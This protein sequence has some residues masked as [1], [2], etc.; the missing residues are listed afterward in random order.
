MD[1][2]V[3]TSYYISIWLTPL[4][5]SLPPSLFI[6]YARFAYYEYIKLASEEEPAEEEGSDSTDSDMAVDQSD[7]TSTSTSSPLHQDPDGDG[8]YN[9]DPKQEKGQNYDQDSEE[10]ESESVVYHDEVK[11]REDKRSSGRGGA[12]GEGKESGVSSQHHSRK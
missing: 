11:A 12:G 3:Y 2:Y 8:Y 10:P 5:L 6:F 4:S 7:N 9:A 1:V